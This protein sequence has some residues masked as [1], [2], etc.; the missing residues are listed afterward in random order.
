MPRAPSGGLPG[1]PFISFWK[2]LTPWTS[3]VGTLESDCF[4][5]RRAGGCVLALMIVLSQLIILYPVAPLRRVFVD[6]LR[7]RRWVSRDSTVSGHVARGISFWCC[8]VVWTLRRCGPERKSDPDRRVS[9]AHESCTRGSETA[10]RVPAHSLQPRSLRGFPNG[11]DASH[12]LCFWEGVFIWISS[13]GPLRPVR[14]GAPCC[15]PQL[16]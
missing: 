7:F 1:Q 3:A 14:R 8:F 6:V 10:A 13:F 16:R 11:S 2:G 15:L 9:G 4:G 12:P 5:R